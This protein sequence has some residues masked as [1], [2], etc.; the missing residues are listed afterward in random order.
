MI[1]IVVISRTIIPS[2]SL[3]QQARRSAEFMAPLSHF[4]L[5]HTLWGQYHFNFH[6][7]AQQPGRS[8]GRWPRIWNGSQ[9]QRRSN[10][11]QC[12]PWH[13]IKCPRAE[14]T[15]LTC[16]SPSL[17]NTGQYLSWDLTSAQT[18]DKFAKAGVPS[19]TDLAYY[20]SLPFTYSFLPSFTERD[21]WHTYR[22]FSR[23][24]EKPD[25]R[26]RRMCSKTGFLVCPNV[27]KE[28]KGS[29]GGINHQC[30]RI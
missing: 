8:G 21:R 28:E 1:I 14:A 12:F 3:S 9:P 20:F 19:I 10:Q 25:E 15:Y 16:S 23:I 30:L 2:S 24:S 29:G 5:T 17:P 4:T 13:H 27:Q 6:W 18:L 26:G 7:P 22:F 11:A